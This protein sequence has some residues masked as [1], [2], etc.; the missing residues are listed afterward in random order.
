MKIDIV[1]PTYNSEA[2]VELLI[3]RLREWNQVTNFQ[4]H[5][6][7]VDDASSDNTLRY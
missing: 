3:Q 2:S 7:F 1:I 6:I 5:F 4:T